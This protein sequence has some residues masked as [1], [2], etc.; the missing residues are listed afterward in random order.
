MAN[1]NK[2]D[3]NAMLAD[4]KDMPKIKIITDEKALK[5][6]AEAECTLPRLRIM[7]Q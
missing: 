6:T 4:N 1:E 2:K 5:N 7:I 3:F